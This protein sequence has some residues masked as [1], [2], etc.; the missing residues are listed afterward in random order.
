MLWTTVLAAANPIDHVVDKPLITSADGTP[1]LT[2]HMITMVI[3]ATL[4]VVVM[5]LAA[6]AIATGP[7]KDGVD[8]YVTKGK[9]SHMI[10]VIVVYL[11]DNVFEPQLGHRTNRFLP[12]L[13][14]VFFFILFI[15]I[16]GLVPIVDLQHAFG[17]HT[18]WIGGTPT[19]NIAVT[20]ALALIA[21][22]V[23]NIAGLKELGL[24]G[25]L[26]HL[27][28][29]VPLT[30][31]MLPVVLIMIPVELMGILI[32]PGALAIRLFAN[33]TAGHV[34]LAVLMGFTGQALDG[35][36]L[37]AGAPVTLISVL[38]ATAI[39]F[40]ELFV[41]FLQAFIF[42]FLTCLFIAQLSHHDEHH[43]EHAPAHA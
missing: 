35:L 37:V 12:F 14:T 25:Y 9:L 20:G 27:T 41:A 29:G 8:R 6:K 7:E 15:N 4:L 24:K 42:A 1:L 40:L 26:M 32:K 30:L 31:G 39:M 11:R 5:N 3:V 10:E 17:L 2:M 34:L 38:A 19:G 33:M 23:I 36:G 13:L 28:G 18:T 22:F 43:E 16:F 21:F